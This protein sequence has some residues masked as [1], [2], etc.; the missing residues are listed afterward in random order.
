MRSEF[1]SIKRYLQASRLEGEMKHLRLRLTIYTTALSN[2]IL[3]SAVHATHLS[4][5]TKFR[6]LAFKAINDWIDMLTQESIKLARDESVSKAHDSSTSRPASQSAS[7]Q[8]VEERS[9]AYSDLHAQREELIKILQVM[10]G[11]AMKMVKR[12]QRDIQTLQTERDSIEMGGSATMAFASS[13]APG[14]V[15]TD[16]LDPNEIFAFQRL[17][18]AQTEPP[19]PS[20]SRAVLP[21]I[22]LTDDPPDYSTLPADSNLHATSLDLSPT[23]HPSDL[24]IQVRHHYAN[25][26]SLIAIGQPIEALSTLETAY[27]LLTSLSPTDSFETPTTTDILFLIA[28]TSVLPTLKRTT[29]ARSALRVIYT[30]PTS[31]TSSTTPTQRYTAAH[32]LAQLYTF[33]DGN[34]ND[35]TIDWDGMSMNLDKAK[36]YVVAAVKGRKRVLG[37]GHPDTQR[38]VE[39]LATLCERVGSA[40]GGGSAREVLLELLEVRRGIFAGDDREEELGVGEWS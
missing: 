21:R 1:Y 24:S 17:A 27:S 7:A 8:T 19:E 29:R 5:G 23:Y 2:P 30:S 10:I 38:S 18:L 34:P 14:P 35:P 36:E 20:S 15:A 3:L 13:S 25:A 6:A 32:L 16:D 26:Q 37:L 28:Q 40:G 9:D 12:S 4:F 33:V 39:L 31:P 22:H 11:T